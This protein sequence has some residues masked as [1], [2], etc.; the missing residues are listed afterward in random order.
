MNFS[1]KNRYNYIILFIFYISLLFGYYFDENLNLGAMGDWF[2]TDVPVIKAS[3]IDLKETLLNY[4]KFGHRHSPVYLIFLSVFYEFGF[5]LD[6][7]RF[8][9]LHI[10]LILVFLFYRCLVFKFE[11]IEKNLVFI[12]SLSLFLSPTFR[13]LSIWPSTRIIGLIFFTLS[14]Y[15]FLKYQKYN[16]QVF[17]YKNLVYLIISSYIS[18]NF[19]IFIIYFFYEYLIREGIKKIIF[20][21]L[22]CLIF[23]I[24][25]F[26]YV[27]ILG[28]NFFN[29]G[30]PG[31]VDGESIGLSFN[32][33]NKV[34]L[35]S[36]I[37]FF[38]LIPFLLNKNFLRDFLQFDI[39]N[40]SVSFL[41]CSV[42]IYFFDYVLNFT[43]GGVFF[44]ISN[45]IFGNNLFF[46]LV[47]FISL[48]L[49]FYFSKKSV[50]NFLLFV[51]LIISNIQNT[52]YHKY[53]DPL[54]I[55]LFFTIIST[56]LMNK[57]FMKKNN[58]CYL[59]IF[60]ILFICMRFYKN[61]IIL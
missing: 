38:H 60:Y 35:I 13:S 37:I 32:F 55:I 23:S 15:E 29:A 1:Q 22:F 49:L 59:F 57:F 19:S 40:I 61:Y 34:L 42:C 26:Y 10:S 56:D 36:S 21:I 54:I 48:M 12:L 39:K 24:P 7:I 11:D 58:L 18:P 17:I 30:T 25:A 31:V 45:Y 28:I 3:A 51:I 2:H 20:F 43:G 33:S 53:F 27:F 14:I 41:V 6:I 50:G 8:V 5:S 9:H 47:S 46:F 16:K 52:I 4:E 44:Q